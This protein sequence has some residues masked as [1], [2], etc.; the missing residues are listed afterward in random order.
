MSL[1]AHVHNQTKPSL[2]CTANK[3]TNEQ[4]NETL[5]SRLDLL[6]CAGVLSWT[7]QVWR[8]QNRFQRRALT[9]HSPRASPHL[10]V[11]WLGEQAVHDGLEVP[12]L[13]ACRSF[14]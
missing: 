2:L 1:D 3:L 8:K 12:R 14:L 4:S 7:E 13:Q 10:G 6:D 5:F 9:N 11:R